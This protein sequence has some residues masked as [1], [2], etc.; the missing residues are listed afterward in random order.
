MCGLYLSLLEETTWKLHQVPHLFGAKSWDLLHWQACKRTLC[1]LLSTTPIPTPMYSQSRKSGARAGSV[2]SLRYTL[3]GTPPSEVVQEHLIREAV[4]GSSWETNVWRALSPSL[5]S[6]PPSP[7]PPPLAH[8]TALLSIPVG[9]WALICKSI[10][11]EPHVK[12]HSAQLCQGH[13]LLHLL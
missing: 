9:F 12:I 11:W 10:P 4:S 8:Q 3:G 1:S 2:G 6:S 5:L 13:S 7:S